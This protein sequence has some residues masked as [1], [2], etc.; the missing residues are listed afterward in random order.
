MQDVSPINF[1]ADHQN[2][3]DCPQCWTDYPK[4]CVCT[5][6][7]HA[8]LLEFDEKRGATLSRFCDLCGAEATKGDKALSPDVT[9]INNGLIFSQKGKN[10]M[11]DQKVNATYTATGT[12]EQE[13][14]EHLRAAANC[15]CTVG[16]IQVKFS[17]GETGTGGNDAPLSF[18]VNLTKIE[19]TGE[20]N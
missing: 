5:G 20:S 12:G 19:S 11:N 10:K 2:R 8:E 16:L 17:E 14:N 7:I 13:L 18:A 4:R 6:F 1:N 15:G 3:A 9:P